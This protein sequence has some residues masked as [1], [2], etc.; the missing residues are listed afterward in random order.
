MKLDYPKIRGSRPV[1]KNLTHDQRKA[2][3]LIPTVVKSFTLDEVSFHNR[4]VDEM[5]FRLLYRSSL[6][7]LPNLTMNNWLYHPEIYLFTKMDPQIEGYHKITWAILELSHE[8]DGAHEDLDSIP[9]L[10]KYKRHTIKGYVQAVDKM[11]R[12]LG[13]VP[14]VKP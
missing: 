2:I 1:W 4:W 5:E 6:C 8:Q 11:A 7:G 3:T 12:L 10:Q 9:A 14:E 13:W